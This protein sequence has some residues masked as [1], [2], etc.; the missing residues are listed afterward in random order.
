LILA[1]ALNLTLTVNGEPHS[2]V[3]R[4]AD[5]T[6]LSVLRDDLF[7]TGTKEGCGIGVCGAC[8]VIV[9]GEMVSA[10]IQLAVLADGAEVRTIEGLGDHQRL[11]PIQR[12]FVE[13]GGLQCGICT[14]GQ[15]MAARALLDTSPDPSEK[16]VKEWMVGNL[17]RCT[18]YYKIVSSILAAAEIERLER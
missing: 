7:L 1:P 18:G 4:S 12:S 13:Q 15:V 9:N 5:R 14:P 2:I 10:C 3:I 8:T 17:C 16:E 11:D 6:L